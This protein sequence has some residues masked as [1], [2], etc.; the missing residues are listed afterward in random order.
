VLSGLLYVRRVAARWATRGGGH[1]M[2]MLSDELAQWLFGLVTE[3]DW[4]RIMLKRMELDTLT[5]IVTVIAKW[6]EPEEPVKQ[7]A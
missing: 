4:D 5:E 6:H 7:S 2:Q 3:G 1:E